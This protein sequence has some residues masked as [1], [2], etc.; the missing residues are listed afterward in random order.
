MMEMSANR[1]LPGDWHN[2]TSGLSTEVIRLI[3][4]G[5]RDVIVREVSKLAG[6]GDGRWREPGRSLLAHL[7]STPDVCLKQEYRTFIPSAQR[8]T[9]PRCRHLLLAI[10]TR[11]EML[12]EALY[13]MDFALLDLRK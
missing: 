9:L 2:V 10:A 6:L 3:G 11:T 1:L 5:S 12:K 8:Y 7:G 13:V 4:N